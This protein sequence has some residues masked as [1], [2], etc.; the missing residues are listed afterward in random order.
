MHDIT[1]GT[2][3]FL[4]AVAACTFNWLTVDLL[5]KQGWFVWLTTP[6]FDC[7]WLKR[8]TSWKVQC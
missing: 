6:G 3:F 1:Q 4:S 8:N 2:L 5:R 7:D